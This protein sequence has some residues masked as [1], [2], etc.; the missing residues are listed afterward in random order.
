MA[1]ALYVLAALLGVAVALHESRLG[2][3]WPPLAGRD[4]RSRRGAQ[5]MDLREF[6]RRRRGLPPRP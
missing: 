4:R 5:L 6:E 3:L 1:D 2:P